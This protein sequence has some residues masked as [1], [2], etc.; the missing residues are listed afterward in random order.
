MHG[1]IRPG[2]LGRPGWLPIASEVTADRRRGTVRAIVIRRSP[3]RSAPIVY[4][5]TV[6]SHLPIASEVSVR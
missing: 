4:E 5:V 1:K 3:V 2:W 6:N